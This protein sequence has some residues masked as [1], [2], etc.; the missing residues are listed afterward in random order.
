MCAADWRYVSSPASEN[1][2]GGTGTGVVEQAFDL[3][4]AGAATGRGAS[5]LTDRIDSGGAGGNGSGDAEGADL[6]TSADDG[7]FVGTAGIGS[8]R[9]HPKALPDIDGGIAEEAGQ[10]ATADGH[11]LASDIE[12][13]F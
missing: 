7:P 11:R 8:P 5:R 6:V 9:K 12:R 3:G 1:G 4:A 2:S 13:A 10:P